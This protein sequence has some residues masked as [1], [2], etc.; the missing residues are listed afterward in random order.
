ML[1]GATVF[2]AY[3]KLVKNDSSVAISDGNNNKTNNNSNNNDN[4]YNA[5]LGYSPKHDED[6]LVCR[7]K[8]GSMLVGATW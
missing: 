1:Q 2:I 6:A 3:W 8:C 4:L 7:P 5:E